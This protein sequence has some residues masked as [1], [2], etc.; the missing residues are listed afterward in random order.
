MF[1]PLFGGVGNPTRRIDPPSVSCVAGGQALWL[2]GGGGWKV[3]GSKQ[4]EVPLITTRRFDGERQAWA[5]GG[6]SHGR[7]LRE[8]S[9]IRNY[10]FLEIIHLF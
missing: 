8:S 4:A 7:I 9:E 6:V 5:V 1:Q 3:C 2:V 10:E